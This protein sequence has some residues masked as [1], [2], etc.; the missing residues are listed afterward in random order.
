MPEGVE[1]NPPTLF[2]N[3]NWYSQV[4]EIVAGSS[5]LKI[6]YPYHLETLFLGMYPGKIM[7]K[8][9]LPL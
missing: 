4:A 8:I 6:G 2:M 7:L 3:V 5:A 1:R 9:K